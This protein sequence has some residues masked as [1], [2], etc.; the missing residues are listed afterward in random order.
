MAD[1][2][3]TYGKGSRDRVKKLEDYRKRYDK[4]K[5]FN[6]KKWK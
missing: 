2:I 6:N 5:G 1:K 3:K 4:I